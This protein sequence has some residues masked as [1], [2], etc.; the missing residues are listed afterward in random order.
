MLDNIRFVNRLAFLIGAIAIFILSAC[1]V[2]YATYHW[3]RIKKIIV[4]GDVSHITKND[5]LA[6]VQNKLYGTFFTLNIDVVQNTFEQIPWIKS[7]HVVR[8]FP[9]S[10]TIHVVEYNAIAD[11]G[12]NRLLSEDKQIFVGSAPQGKLP[13]FMVPD[14]QISNALSTFN[15]I[16]PFL[17]KHNEALKTMSYNGVGLIKLTLSSGMQIVMCGGDVA[18][19][20]QLLDKYWLQVGQVESGVSYINMCYKNALAIK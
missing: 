10:I 16:K 12:N 2:Y 17:N 1:F 7:V 19:N 11:L 20:L 3:F 14:G 6:L 4:Q 15:K 18:I 9:D 13:L 5:V 8:E